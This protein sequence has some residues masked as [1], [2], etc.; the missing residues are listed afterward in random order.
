MLDA[1]ATPDASSQAG[2]DTLERVR[3]AVQSAPPQ[4][5]LGGLPAQNADFIEAV[6]GNFP[7]MIALIAVITFILLARAFRS[8][9]LPLKAVILN[10][11]SVGAAW[12]V[13]ALVWQEGTARA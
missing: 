1:F 12:G 3:D 9:L 10:I 11:I 13:L 5:H 6:Y 7:L 8:L 2:R 4:V